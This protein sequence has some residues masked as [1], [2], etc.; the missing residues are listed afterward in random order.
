M[1]RLISLSAVIIQSNIGLL[2][3][4][5]AVSVYE[6]GTPFLFSTLSLFSSVIFLPAIYGRF[7]ELST[8]SEASSSW[9]ELFK[10]NWIN[11]WVVSLLLGTPLLLLIMLSSET[12]FN[13]RILYPAVHTLLLLLSIYIYPYVF[14]KHLRLE[15]IVLGWNFLI[16][17]LRANT[18]LIVITLCCGIGDDI[19][20]EWITARFGGN[21]P[22]AMGCAYIHDTM[23]FFL[24]LLVFNVACMMVAGELDTH[25]TDVRTP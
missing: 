21:M 1:K 3:I 10:K 14:L 20:R 19:S 25:M 9:I 13:R 16:K 22:M 7:A 17:N 11:Y 15:A 24:N 5:S 4:L 23:F 12:V 8:A 2:F 18:L 6:F